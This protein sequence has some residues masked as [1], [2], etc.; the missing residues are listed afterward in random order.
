ME[1]PTLTLREVALLVALSSNDTF[2]GCLAQAGQPTYLT[3][4]QRVEA[5][6]ILERIGGYQA[7]DAMLK[8]E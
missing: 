7:L 8:T 2:E 3:E 5:K 6:K 1:T 4:S